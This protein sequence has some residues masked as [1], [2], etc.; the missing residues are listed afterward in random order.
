MRYL[1]YLCIFSLLIFISCSSENELPGSA[2]VAD[3]GPDMEEPVCIGTIVLDGSESSDPDGDTLNYTWTIKRI[4]DGS[5][6]T[7]NNSNEARASITPD[8]VG[9]YVITLSVSD[10][11][12]NPVTDEVTLN[13]TADTGNPPVAD[14]GEDRTVGVNETVTLDASNSSDPDGDE[15]TYQWTIS[16]TP[17]GS[18]ATITN[19]DQ[20]QAQ[21]IPDRAGN[22]VFRLRVTDAAGSCVSEDTDN[23]IITAE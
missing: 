15:L 4:P 11:I 10:G 13:I 16:S 20:P 19:A 6:A 22:Y 17:V 1:E 23:L 9:Q 12:H 7:L 18:Q 2:P 14:A 21:F 5:T 8:V 3:A